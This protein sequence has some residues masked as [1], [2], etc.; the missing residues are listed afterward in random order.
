[1]TLVECNRPLGHTCIA[2]SVV[3]R[4][5]S[6]DV[7]MLTAV[8]PLTPRRADCCRA[9][10]EG[11]WLHHHALSHMHGS[12]VQGFTASAGRPVNRRIKQC[13]VEACISRPT[14]LYMLRI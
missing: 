8:P 13:L 3:Y 5:S 7:Y 4:K 10:M 6:G 9:T 1:M 14:T 2:T 11:S 12:S